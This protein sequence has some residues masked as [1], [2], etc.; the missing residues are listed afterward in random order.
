MVNS[1]TFG[2]ATASP[3]SKAFGWLDVCI[4]ADGSPLRIPVHVIAGAQ[5]GPRLTVL[6]AQHGYEISEIEVARQVVETV[7]PKA[8]RGTLVV[9]PVANPIAF[10]GGT[11]CAWVDSL[12]GDNGNMNRVWPGNPDG[13]LTERM[14][15]M[16][17]E[18]II[19]GSD[20]A[21]DLHDG[22]TAPPGLTVGYGYALMTEDQELSRRIYEMSVASGFDILVKR[23]VS[24]L[25]GSLAPFAIDQGIPCFAC[26]VGEFYGFQLEEN[27]KPAAK[28][29]RTVPQC[30][31][32][33]LHNIMKHLGM[34]EGQ[35]KLPSRQVLIPRENNLRPKHGGA[36][37]SEFTGDAIGRVVPKDTLLGT[38]VSP[39]DFTVLDEIRAPYEQNMIIAVTYGHPFKRV[40]AGD[41]GY[42]AADMTTAEWIDNVA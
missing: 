35:P 6:S 16:L 29:V 38:V 32:T 23:P 13:W 19:K 24:T 26:E 2:S 27:E 14:V 15:Y 36:L 30:G 28:P 5:P 42:I 37:Y 7:D 21:A 12:Y 17:S 10:E 20:V 33:A 41:Y 39:Y 3:G 22:T 25:G 9:V 11:R 40:N 18:Q 31:V 34:L 8:L 1:V 4:M